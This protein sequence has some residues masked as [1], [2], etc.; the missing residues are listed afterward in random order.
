MTMDQKRSNL[1]QLSKV[2]NT[3]DENV[4]SGGHDFSRLPPE[5]KLRAVASMARFVSQFKGAARAGKKG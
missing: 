1:E 5:Q 2:L 4:L 3:S